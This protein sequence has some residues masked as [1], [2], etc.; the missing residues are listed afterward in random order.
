MFGYIRPMQSELKVREFEHFKSCYCSL[1]HVLGNNYGLASR[2]ILNYDFTFLAILMWSEDFALTFEHKRCIASPCRKKC[3]CRP[4]E[5]L[6][7]S[8]AYSIILAYWKLKDSVQDE[9]F[10]RRTGARMVM[11]VLR[12]AYKRA[13]KK[14]PQYDEHVRNCLSELAEIEKNND[15]SLDKAADTF[16]RIL[17]AAANTSE[18][19]E[20]KRASE[21]ILYHMGRFIYIVDAYNDLEE[22]MQKGRY[23]PIAAR[24]SLTEPV[25]DEEL[26]NSLEITMRHSLNLLSSAYELM[27]ENPWSEVIRNIIYLGM[28]D[29]SARVMNGTFT[30]TRQRLPKK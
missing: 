12:R 28:P 16:A 11:L 20:K 6:D 25:L 18:E 2:F 22:D 8:A 4:D 9:G 5:S 27:P 30:N 17:S 21:Q 15:P 10:F 7:S 24:Y 23:N 1:C 26:Q 13:A 29:V 3:L 19:P 14:Y